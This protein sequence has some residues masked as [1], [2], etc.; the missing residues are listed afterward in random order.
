[1]Q[2]NKIRKIVVTAILSAIST[3]LMMLDFPIGI[4]PSFL[5]LDFSEL[6]ALLSSFSLGPIYGVLVCLIK[7][8]I[9]MPFSDTGAVGELANFL[10]GTCFVL[11][12]GLIYKRFKTRKGAIAGAAIG[13]V[14]MAVASV[15]VNYYITYPMYSSLYFGGNMQ[16]VISMYTI[17]YSKIDTLMKAL[18]YCNMPFTFVKGL[19][20]MLITIGI[21]KRLSP[22]IKGI[23]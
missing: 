11:P 14:M 16:A 6:P 9:N 17:L 2:N 1:M 21:Y 7:N 20:N 4:A 19:L 10:I 23:K 12:A 13:A 3:V 22:R 8:L 15:P 5:E 18:L